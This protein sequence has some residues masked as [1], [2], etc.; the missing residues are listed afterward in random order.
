[1]ERHLALR[2]LSGSLE[3]EQPWPLRD[4]TGE[5]REKAVAE[6]EGGVLQTPGKVGWARLG[7]GPEIGRFNPSKPVPL[8]PCSLV[9]VP[10][11]RGLGRTRLG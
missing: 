5:G 2:D 4:S 6:V 3:V 1:M 11:E 9:T 8:S 10:K 7:M